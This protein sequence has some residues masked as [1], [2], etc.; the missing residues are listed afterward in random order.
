[1]LCTT[2]STTWI[3]T[4]WAVCEEIFITAFQ[5]ALI[6][7][8][9]H[10][11]A[12]CSWICGGL[13]ND[14]LTLAQIRCSGFRA[15][16]HI[17]QIWLMMWTKWSWNA[18]HNKIC[19]GKIF[20]I[21]SRR[22]LLISFEVAEEIITKMQDVSLTTIQGIDLLLIDIESD[23]GESAVSNC[24]DKRKSHVPQADDGDDCCLGFDFL[25]ESLRNCAVNCRLCGFRS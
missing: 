23:H 14:Q 9:F 3:F 19:F 6:K 8:R 2:P 24:L 10:F 1:M 21:R 15:L 22:E 17:S 25:H 12:S 4:L 18:E 13:E 11:I 20:W 5:P 7:N 16:K